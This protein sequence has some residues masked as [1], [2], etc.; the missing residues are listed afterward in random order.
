MIQL[1]ASTD[2][3]ADDVLCAFLGLSGSCWS[4]NGVE[5]SSK[6][7][8]Y[9]GRAR[10]KKTQTDRRDIPTRDDATDVFTDEEQTSMT[11]NGPF[12][13]LVLAKSEKRQKLHADVDG[14][15]IRDWSSR[16][17][18]RFGGPRD[19]DPKPCSDPI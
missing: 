10:K 9:H 19:G 3:N 11:P 18:E 1:V 14:Q 7:W 5:G 2:D 13:R 17:R 16:K 6:S 15:R 8:F 4:F 12:E